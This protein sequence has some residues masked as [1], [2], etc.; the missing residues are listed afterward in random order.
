MKQRYGWRDGSRSRRMDVGKVAPVL[1]ALERKHGVLTPEQVLR[2]ATKKSSPLHKWF[3]WDDTEAARLYRM[4]QARELIRAV[5]V[6]VTEG[7]EYT[8]RAFV[9]L[10]DPTVYESTVH[11]LS[12][13]EK[14][15]LLLE[16]MRDDFEV[17]R[18]RYEH[19]RELAAVFAAFDEAV[20]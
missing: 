4:T 18:K 20:A 15:A 1:K 5:T 3:E 11:V 8:I 12:D 17:F 9:H 16:R 7:D 14:R 13:P 6:I 2:E 19:I 10:G